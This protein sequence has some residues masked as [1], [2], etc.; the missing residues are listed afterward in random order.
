M[1]TSTPIT[2]ARTTPGDD[3]TAVTPGRSA[4][5]S[6]RRATVA[7][8]AAAGLGATAAAAA[9]HA[10]GVSF[11]IDGEAIPLLAFTQMAF[12]WTLVG[13]VVA[14]SLRKRAAQPRRRFLQSTIALTLLSCVPSMTA[15]A[16]NGTRAALVATHLV[17][18]VIAIP[19]LARQLED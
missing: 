4:R 8:A 13:G 5:S 17:A 7:A 1:T 2:N 19:L 15:S 14:G 11:A 6:L 3:A 9:L 18:A 16:S 12:L 10:A